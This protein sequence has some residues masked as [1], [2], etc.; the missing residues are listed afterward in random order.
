MSFIGE[1]FRDSTEFEAEDNLLLSGSS[2]KLEA[3][4]WSAATFAENKREL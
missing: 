3:G 4:R 2:I 1:S